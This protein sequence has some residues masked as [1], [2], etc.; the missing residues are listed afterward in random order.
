MNTINEIV[1][2]SQI[3]AEQIGLTSSETNI[4]NLIEELRAQF[5]VFSKSKKLEFIIINKLANHQTRF[6]TD[7][8]KL[9]T[10]LTNL[11][12]NAFKY[13]KFGSVELVIRQKDEY[14]E[15]SIKDTGIGIPENKLEVIFDR[16][17]QRDVSMT[18]EFE[19]LGLGLAIA[20][21]YVKM[22]GGK[23][24]VESE[25]GNGSQFYF[26]IPYLPS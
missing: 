25:E 10:I 14:L 22:L 23:I 20:K 9:K 4:D 3:Q 24:W 13:T 2:I 1:E 15:F 8:L 7:T 11:I 26:T 16:F 5:K 17:M 6:S 18:R 21:S 19:G 12:G